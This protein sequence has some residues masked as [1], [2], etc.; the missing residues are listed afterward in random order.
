MVATLNW[1]FLVNSTDLFQPLI[2]KKNGYDVDG[3][4]SCHNNWI[5]QPLITKKNGCD[6]GRRESL[7]QKGFEAYRAQTWSLRL[8]VLDLNDFDLSIEIIQKP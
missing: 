6:G 4:A 8:P 1:G 5:F 2:T 3:Y 7:P